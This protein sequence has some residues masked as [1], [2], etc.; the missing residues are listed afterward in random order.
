MFAIH[1]KITG[2]WLPPP[3]NAQGKRQRAGGTFVE[4]GLMPR[5]FTSSSAAKN[6]LRYWLA[7]HIRQVWY[8]WSDEYDYTKDYTWESTP[9]PNRNPDEWE[10]VEVT[11]VLKQG[12]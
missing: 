11:V 3:I 6:A 8:S 1:N 7:G 10:V 12:E 4:P 2:L 5:L 9:Q